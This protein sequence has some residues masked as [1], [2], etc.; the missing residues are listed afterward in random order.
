MLSLGREGSW[1]S[2]HSRHGPSSPW[3]GLLRSNL[4]LTCLEGAD[5]QELHNSRLLAAGG[6]FQKWHG[7][8][9]APT[10]F[11]P[12]ETLRWKSRPPLR[13]RVGSRRRAPGYRRDP[14]ASPGCPD[15]HWSRKTW[16]SCVGDCSE[17][18][19][20]A[21]CR[22]RSFPM[23]GSSLKGHSQVRALWEEAARTCLWGLIHLQGQVLRDIWISYMWNPKTLKS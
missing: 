16:T 19:L 15:G 4:L 3:S 21:V 2:S 9:S 10:P 18:T 5:P 14:G 8:E 20:V 11:A 13:Q 17:T 12:G 6:L 22:S 23:K 7:Q 1:H